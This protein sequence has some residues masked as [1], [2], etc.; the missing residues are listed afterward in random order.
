MS[1]SG[2]RY[3]SVLI[4]LRTLKYSKM[5]GKMPEILAKDTASTIEVG[6]RMIVSS[7]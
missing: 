3:P 1:P 4:L 2:S 7:I 5:K 6:S